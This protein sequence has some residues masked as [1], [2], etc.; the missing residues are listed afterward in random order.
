MAVTVETGSTLTFDRFW[1]WLKRHPN[2]ILRAGTPEATLYDHEDLHWHLEED[3]DRVPLVQLQRG[4]QLLGELA[5]EVRDVLFVQ[6]GP[7]PD[8]EAGHFLFELWGGGG[9]EPYAVY[10]FVLVHAF[11]EEGGHRPQLKQ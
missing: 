10:H 6:A 7:D 4:K 2:C 11:D 3:E 8:G 1:R 5:I 9:D